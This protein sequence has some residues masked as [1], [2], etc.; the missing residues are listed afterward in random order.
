[1]KSRDV[2]VFCTMCFLALTVTNAGLFLND[3]WMSAAQLT[4]IGQGHQ[5]TYN[6]GTFG[7]FANGTAGTYMET[8][9]NVLMYSLALPIVALPMFMI[10]SLF[11]TPPVLPIVVW[12]ICGLLAAFTA[13]I[14]TRRQRFGVGGLIWIAGITSILICPPVAGDAS[15]V[16]AIVTTNILLYGGF[17]VL[18]RR[19]ID[20]LIEPNLQW[21]AWMVTMAS[22]TLLFWAGTGKDH[23]LVAF[24]VLCC[25]YYMLHYGKTSTHLIP[26]ALCA[27]LTL[28]IRTEVGVFIILAFIALLL[29]Y[30]APHHHLGIGLGV[31]GIGTIPFFVNNLLVSGNL[32]TP[33]FLMA[34]AATYTDNVVDHTTT[35]GLTALTNLPHYFNPVDGLQILLMPA[36]GAL[37]LIVFGIALV[38]FIRRPVHIDRN[39]LTLVGLGIASFIYYLVFCGFSMHMDTGIMPDIR[40]ASAAY[41]PVTLAA[42]GILTRLYPFDARNGI[43]TVLIGTLVAIP[44]TLIVLLTVPMFGASY[45]QFNHLINLVLV[46]IVAIVGITM[47]GMRRNPQLGVSLIAVTM[48]VWQI[49]MC[50]VYGDIK[51]NGYPYMPVVDWLHHLL[52]VW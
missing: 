38:A 15:A 4:Q 31:T 16:I 18:V 1:M 17:A 13:P 11:V 20:L 25:C 27:G 14:L 26:A 29:I 41:A 5:F 45:P 51:V 21:Y 7:Y 30:R 32:L 50:F 43:R 49:V 23:M 12:T 36:S 37:G 24:V 19:I 6:E 28:W 35:F 39:I 33:P 34:N 8:R 3:E 22:S 46:T 42:L 52:F 48:I 40:Y 44:L 10:T 9:N 47:V 2:F